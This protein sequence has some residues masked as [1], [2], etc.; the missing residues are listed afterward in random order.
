MAT[1]FVNFAFDEHLGFSIFSHI[2]KMA[3]LKKIQMFT[4]CILYVFLKLLP[5]LLD[6]L[7]MCSFNFNR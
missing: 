2:D 5:E 3:R 7:S 6:I 1:H 4:I